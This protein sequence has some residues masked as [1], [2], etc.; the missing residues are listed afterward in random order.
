MHNNPH[1]VAWTVLTG[2]FVLFLVL[3][4][5]L[6]FG[7][8]TLLLNS[9]RGQR[10]DIALA[11]GSVYVTRPSVGVPE[12]LFGS[13]ENLSPGARFATENASRASLSFAPPDNHSTLGTVQLYG[14]TE[15]TILEITTPRFQFSEQPHRISMS[16]TRG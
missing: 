10:A 4:L 15:A 12:A 16:L 1:R 13:M 5:A 2:A 14:D 6:P 11:A 9:T 3:A 8:R 7:V